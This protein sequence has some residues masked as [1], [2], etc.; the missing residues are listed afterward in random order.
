MI[1]L[2]LLPLK[3]K[4]QL[5]VKKGYGIVRKII[6]NSLIHIALISAILV[7]ASF[8]LENDVGY[9]KE[10]NNVLKESNKGLN[11][12]IRKYNKELTYLSTIQE[13]HE[14]F[15]DIIIELGN[16]VPDKLSLSVFSINKDSN[17]KGF[18][19]K[20]S[21][22]AEERDILLNFKDTLNQMDFVEKF[23]LPINNLLK[24]KNVDF[25]FSTTI[26]VD[27]YTKR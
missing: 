19:L 7:G 16:L 15:S 10:Q 24:Q 4:K 17:E 23:D 1:T 14:N 11:S 9:I 22:I 13:E 5:Y 18:V 12:E 2:D 26:Y 6:T 20:M 21:G 8:L 3:E 27:K 25:D